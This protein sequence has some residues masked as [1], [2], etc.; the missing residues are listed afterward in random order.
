MRK[1]WPHLACGIRTRRVFSIQSLPNLVLADLVASLF[2]ENTSGATEDNALQDLQ[3]TPSLDNLKLAPTEIVECRAVFE[4]SS[5]GKLL[6]RHA[7]ALL[8]IGH[9][10]SRP[11]ACTSDC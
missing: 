11:S 4:V 7:C 6:P 10:L 2:S 1:F 9:V 8:E 5:G 3:C